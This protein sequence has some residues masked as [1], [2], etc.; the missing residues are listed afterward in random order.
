MNDTLEALRSLL[1]VAGIWAIWHFLIR[2]AILDDA[3][4]GLFELRDALFDAAR[5]GECGLSFSNPEYKAA[6]DRL[7]SQIQHLHTWS[8][9][10]PLC[11]VFQRIRG[12]GRLLEATQVIPAPHEMPA[13][14]L[15]DVFDRRSADVCTFFMS[16]T[17]PFAYACLW[18][19]AF[20]NR[21]KLVRNQQTISASAIGQE[22]FLRFAKV[23]QFPRPHPAIA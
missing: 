4:Q 9:W 5:T 1:A 6:R 14:R 19:F 15:I 16:R 3:R 11:L 17:S 7:N 18:A 21:K 13:S 2:Q 22:T 20:L 23:D 8:P 12:S 10:T